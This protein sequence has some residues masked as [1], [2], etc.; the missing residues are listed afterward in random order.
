MVKLI[1]GN[2]SS[3][4]SNAKNT[5][6]KIPSNSSSKTLVIKK[7]HVKRR[8]GPLNSDDNKNSGG[9]ELNNEDN[10]KQIFIESNEM[11]TSTGII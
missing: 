7:S 1:N 9:S 8:K 6:I 4:T 5:F 11:L 2:A 3:A 10:D